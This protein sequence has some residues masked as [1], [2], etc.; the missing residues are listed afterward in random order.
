MWPLT[1]IPLPGSCSRSPLREDS[2]LEMPKFR[3]LIND[4]KWFWGWTKYSQSRQH[5]EGCCC[6]ETGSCRASHT[7]LRLPT[8]LAAYCDDRYAPATCNKESFHTDIAVGKTMTNSEPTLGK[9]QLLWSCP[10]VMA[11]INAE[12]RAIT[13]VEWAARML[14]RQT[15]GWWA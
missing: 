5:Q 13:V 2:S 10:W 11:T 3:A 9:T 1:G 7:V 12:H 8:F 14:W 4:Y 15:Y 6:S